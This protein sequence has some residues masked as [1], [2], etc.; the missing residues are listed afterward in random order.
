MAIYSNKVFQAVLVFL[1]ISFASVGQQKA[2]TTPTDYAGYWQIPGKPS[3][4][5]VGGYVKLDMIHDFNPIGSPYYFDVSTIPTNGS[6]GETTTMHAKETRLYIDSRTSTDIGEMKVYVEGDFYGTSGALRMRHAYVEINKRWLAGQYWS[7]FMDETIIPKTLDFEKPAAY[8]FARNAM[9]RR[10][11]FFSEDSYLTLSFEEPKLLGQAPT[12]PG[13]FESPLPDFTMQYRL[14]KKWGHLQVS[15]FVADARYRFDSSGVK[16]IPLY[17]V[18][19]SGKWNV[20]KKDYLI[21]QVLAGAGTARYRG[22]QSVALNM[23][24]DIVPLNDLALTLG[25]H[26]QWSPKLTS[27]LVYNHGIVDN[28]MGQ[29]LSSVKTANYLAGNLI[30]KMVENGFVGIEYLRGE[31]IDYDDDQGVANR[32]QLS[33]KYQFN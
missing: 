10:R 14:S 12:A 2:E 26:H 5:K 29:P 17:G 1:S 22:G 24:G 7:N 27:L 15:G 28:T 33:V 8:A 9:I 31:R 18:N 3:F 6:K 13:K 23:K 32:I 25:F 19:V 20:Y 30:W 11:F 21:Y 16:D 4:I